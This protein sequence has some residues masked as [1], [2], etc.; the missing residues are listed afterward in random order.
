MTY[1]TKCNLTAQATHARAARTGTP[2][3]WNEAR[4]IAVARE[5]KNA[6][7]RAALE[8]ATMWTRRIGAIKQATGMNGWQARKALNADALKRATA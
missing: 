1:R 4:R 8:A 2:I 7:R 5:A 6:A 3:T